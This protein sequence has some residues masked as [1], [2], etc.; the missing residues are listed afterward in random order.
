[1]Y[2]MDNI[3][4]Q[5]IQLFKKEKNF[6]GFLV[7]CENYKKLTFEKIKNY[8]SYISSNFTNDE[9][10]RFGQGHPSK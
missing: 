8:Q 7:I 3:E 5:D 10:F 9:L 6:S 2:H 1:M 4:S